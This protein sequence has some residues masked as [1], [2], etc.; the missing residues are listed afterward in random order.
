MNTEKIPVVILAGGNGTTLGTGLRRSKTMVE[1]CGR[2]LIDH[3]VDFFAH[4]GFRSFLVAAGLGRAE[5]SAH[6]CQRPQLS[7]E[8]VD[9]GD[10]ENTGARLA[11]LREH[12]GGAEQFILTYGDV[13]SDL[14]LQRLLDFHAAHGKT[15]SLAA[16]HIPT[17]FR[18]LGLHDVRD[19]VLGFADRP[20]LQKDFI[21]G[22][23]YV[24]SRE[25]LAL[26]ELTPSASCSFEF[27]VL[28]ALV[29]RRQVMAFRHEG[30][31]QSLDTERDL[32]RLET[33]L[34]SA[35]G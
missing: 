23:F 17:R 19:D 1:V 32:T 34:R 20:I 3:V 18:I 33:Y 29:A 16:V 35:A 15:A 5:L 12:L 11:R 6:L 2:P 10:A 24:L 4:A 28:P 30:Y 14:S 21:S 31:W 27:D 9:T 25:V 26:P 13:I 22:G 8:V 7:I